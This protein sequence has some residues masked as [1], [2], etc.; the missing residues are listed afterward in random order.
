MEILSQHAQPTHPHAHIIIHFSIFSFF[1]LF[2][3]SFISSLV[4]V[5]LIITK[6]SLFRRRAKGKRRRELGKNYKHKHTHTQIH[7]I[8]KLGCITLAKS[9][10]YQGN[11]V[12]ISDAMK[13]YAFTLLYYCLELMGIISLQKYIVVYINDGIA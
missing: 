5:K 9:V 1:F 13:S 7:F 4:R 8:A 10:Q 12:I 3:F 6:L 2:S 11:T